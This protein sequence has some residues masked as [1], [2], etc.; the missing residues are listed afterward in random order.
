M[1][2]IRPVQETAVIVR[3]TDSSVVV[4][5]SD[6]DTVVIHTGGVQG[7]QGPTGPEGPQGDPGPSGS[8]ASGLTFVQAVPAAVWHITHDL[9]YPPAVTVIDTSGDQVEGDV[10]YAGNTITLTFS[11]AFGGTA[12]LS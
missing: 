10:T 8:A 3:P 7:P 9:G 4:R 6:E 5:P 11:A 2:T 1:P 12:Y